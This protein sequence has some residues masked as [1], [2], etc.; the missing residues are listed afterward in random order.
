MK[1]IFKIFYKIKKNPYLIFLYG[2]ATIILT[3]T[4]LLTLP[5]A[6]N[7]GKSVGFINAL[8]T[9]TSAVCVTGMRANSFYQ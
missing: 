4:I 6:S 2:F 5:A 8:F 1:K 9:A 3:G 7:N